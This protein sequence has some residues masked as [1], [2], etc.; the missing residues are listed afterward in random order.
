MGAH[1]SERSGV[2]KC[3]Y[4]PQCRLITSILQEFLA[5][6][7]INLTKMLV[8]VLRTESTGDD[9]WPPLGETPWFR[10]RSSA[11]SENTTSTHLFKDIRDIFKVELSTQTRF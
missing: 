3:I 2:D 11:S 10:F 1:F 5:H 4:S 8:E 6:A 9:G 7:K